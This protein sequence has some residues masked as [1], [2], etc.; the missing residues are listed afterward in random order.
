MPSTGGALDP[1]AAPAITAGCHPGRLS[2]NVHANDHQV[3]RRMTAARGLKTPPSND[4]APDRGQ[5]DDR[6]RST[7]SGQHAL[8]RILSRI[9]FMNC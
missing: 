4:L 8:T 1:E 2:A 6:L 3:N 9:G 7:P 5:G